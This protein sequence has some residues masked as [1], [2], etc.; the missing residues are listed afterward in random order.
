VAGCRYDAHLHAPVRTPLCPCGRLVCRQCVLAAASSTSPGPCGARGRSGD[1]R[2][3]AE[4]PWAGVLVVDGGVLAVPGAVSTV[5]RWVCAYPL[6]AVSPGPN[7]SL[8]LTCTNHLCAVVCL[9]SVGASPASCAPGNVYVPGSE[10]P[11]ATQDGTAEWCVE[12]ASPVRSTSSAAHTDH[13]I[14]SLAEAVVDVVAVGHQHA[15][16]AA[17]ARA[18]YA[19]L[20]AHRQA[21]MQ[22][23]DQ[24]LARKV[25]ALREQ[26]RV[27]VGEVEVAFQGKAAQLVSQVLS[28]RGGVGEARTGE[29]LGGVAVDT[30]AP[31]AVAARTAKYL[32]ELYAALREGDGVGAAAGTGTVNEVDVA[33][34]VTA[35][36]ECELALGDVRTSSVAV[37]KCSL[38]WE[39]TGGLAAVVST[40]KQAESAVPLV[41]SEVR[42]DVSFHPRHLSGVS[43]GGGSGRLCHGVAAVAACGVSTHGVPHIVTVDENRVHVR[44]DVPV[45]VDGT[46]EVSVFICGEPVT[47]SPLRRECRGA[48]ARGNGVSP[49]AMDLQ[50]L[51]LLDV[52]QMPRDHQSFC[53]A[54]CPELGLMAT[55]R[56]RCILITPIASVLDRM[57]AAAMGDVGLLDVA[58]IDAGPCPEGYLLPFFFEFNDSRTDR[59]RD[60]VGLF[61][62]AGPASAR[63]LLVP[64]FE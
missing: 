19:R 3:E 26:H 35:G 50:D 54:V 62:F 13:T 11:A 37:S 17:R 40:G 8:R 48:T 44:L 57:R 22:E 15:A 42:V 5:S 25:A 51:V 59:L 58:M 46:V 49:V 56:D 20:A 18:Q 6:P 12:C 31:A 33:L 9:Y 45:D 7:I 53:I 60:Y 24:Q 34:R 47:G 36:R 52:F 64:D 16:T 29:V 2:A 55:A 1:V 61:A 43:V 27:R 41:A 63:V 39:C 23:L 30:G 28:A 21:A 38:E 4:G 14:V 10:L 32:M